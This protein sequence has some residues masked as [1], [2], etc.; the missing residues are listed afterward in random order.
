MPESASLERRKIIKYFGAELILTS[1]KIGRMGA[2]QKVKDLVQN[3][4]NY[5]WLNQYENK[6]NPFAHYKK[7]AE[8]IYN[9]LDGKIDVF[10]SGIG[11]GGTI[12]GV[13]K[14]LKEKNSDIKIIGVEP[15]DKIKHTIEGL[16]P[17]HE[18]SDNFIPKVLDFNFID[19]IIEIENDEAFIFTREL[20]NVEGI[21]AGISSGANLSAVLK[22]SKKYKG[23]NI[24]FINQD[25]VFKYLS[26]KLFS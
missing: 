20:L 21:P 18:T 12:S 15:K 3:N 25:S 2:F 1:S 23:K 6:N 11:T 10:V 19:E 14:F 24:V 26:T 22:I 5:V 7:T 13:G 9:S 16:Q 17:I 4:D 8:E